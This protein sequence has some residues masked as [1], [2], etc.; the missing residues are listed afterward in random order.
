VPDSHG[1]F[2]FIQADQ[3]AA[4]LL[5]PHTKNGT[6]D[7]FNL[8]DGSLLRQCAVGAS[9]D[10]AVD[11]NSG[12]YYVSCSAKPRVLAIDRKTFE[13]LGETP[14]PGPADILAFD[15]KNGLAYVGH[16]DAGEVWAVNVSS[17]KIEATIPIP[18]GPEG[19]VCDPENNRVF[20][21][22]KKTSEVV[23]IDTASNKL[24]AKWPTSPAQ[25]PHG[26]AMAM[27]ARRLFVAG[28]N[29][30][31]VEM[32]A[33]TG[34]MIASA[35]IAPK[36]DQIAYD[37]GLKRVYCA[38]GTGVMSVVQVEDDGLTSL[39]DVPTHK[40]AHSVAV[41]PKTHAVWTAFADGDKSY[42]LRLTP[43]Q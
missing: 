26:L 16:D 21:N 15:P 28:A 17:G 20:V 27:P 36:V 29:G 38:S 43:A 34:K 9:Q 8:S 40:G 13:I 1:G 10:A 42:L 25:M 3:Q 14:L 4:R 33:G 39:G 30:K 5:A 2:D 18:E 37:S 35:D 41:D 24:V 19:I 6:F 12:K 7:V 23:V 32:D 31:L 11:S 22:A